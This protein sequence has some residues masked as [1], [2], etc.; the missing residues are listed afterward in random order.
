MM[1]FLHNFLG[2]KVSN[3]FTHGALDTLLL[4]LLHR[5]HFSVS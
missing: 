3:S 1:A 2:Q 4:L 5:Q